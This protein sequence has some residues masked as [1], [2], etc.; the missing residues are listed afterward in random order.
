MLATTSARKGS[1]T[2]QTSAILELMAAF[3]E[4]GRD[5]NDHA[6]LSLGIRVYKEYL[7][8]ALKSVKTFTYIGL[9]GPLGKL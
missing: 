9:F 4:V 5:A 1:S 6:W 8:W 2:V 7:H 3:R